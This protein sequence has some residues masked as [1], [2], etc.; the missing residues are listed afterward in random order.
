AQYE[1]AVTLTP[2]IAQKALRLLDIDDIGLEATDRNILTT[3]AT[4][5]KGGPAG[6]KSIAAAVAEE[7]DTIEDVYEPYLMRIGFL[8]RTSRGRTVTDNALAQLN[9]KNKDSQT[10]LL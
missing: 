7:E 1:N 10:S 9:L 8:V 5:F 6:L 2:Q 3:I 4:Q